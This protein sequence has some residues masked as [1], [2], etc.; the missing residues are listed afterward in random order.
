MPII[1]DVLPEEAAKVK[2]LGGLLLPDGVTWVIPDKIKH[3][4]Q[5]AT[6]E[7]GDMVTWRRW[8][9]LP[10]TFT[11]VTYLDDRI[12]A[13]LQSDY[14]FF[15]FVRSKGLQ[16]EIWGSTCVHCGTLQEDD[17]AFRYE[18]NVLHPVTLDEGMEIRII[19]LALQ[20]DY[21]IGGS[22]IFDTLITEV[23]KGR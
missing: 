18:S 8:Q 20:F 4:V 7:K 15:K 12:S 16:Q 10:I 2:K 3:V 22:E 9:G 14:P 19:Y 1:I 17:D 13:S 11:D 6:F 5:R 23:M 21:Y